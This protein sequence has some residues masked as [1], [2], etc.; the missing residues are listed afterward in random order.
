MAKKIKFKYSK[1]LISN[2]L[3]YKLYLILDLVLT[4]FCI[5]LLIFYIIGNYQNFQDKTQQIILSVLSY[6]SIFNGLLSIF[7]IIESIIKLITEK[8]KLKT[9]LLLIYLLFAV[10][11]CIVFSSAS[12]IISFLSMGIK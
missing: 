5:T 10:I 3:T 12:N 6:S 9:T 4:V 1:K 11:L 2:T 8:R 7:L